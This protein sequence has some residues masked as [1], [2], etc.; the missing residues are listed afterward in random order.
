MNHKY[1]SGDSL[2]KLNN[3]KITDEQDQYKKWCKDAYKT[4]K[5]RML[6]GIGKK[7]GRG[8]ACGFGHARLIKNNDIVRTKFHNTNPKLQNLI[9]VS[10]KDYNQK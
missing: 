7:I 10:S 1:R 4:D 8:G 9:V 6:L 5:C 2:N 3:S